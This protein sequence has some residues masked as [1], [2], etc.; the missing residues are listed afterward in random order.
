MYLYIAAAIKD[1]ECVCVIIIDGPY[2]YISSEFGNICNYIMY[3]DMIYKYFHRMCLWW[4]IR[5]AREHTCT[6]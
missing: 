4:Q 3:R 1:H 5:F 6:I 2:I